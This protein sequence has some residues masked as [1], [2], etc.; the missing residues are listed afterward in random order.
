MLIQLYPDEKVYWA[1]AQSNILIFTHICITF[2]MQASCF[3]TQQDHLRVNKPLILSP[4]CWNWRSWIFTLFT[5]N[6]VAKQLSCYLAPKKVLWMRINW[7]REKS[8]NRFCFCVH[9]AVPGYKAA[10][11]LG[12]PA[13]SEGE[14]QLWVWRGR[15]RLW[16]IQMGCSH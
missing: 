4:Q 1:I 11:S 12:W 14:W 3:C 10:I 5:K 8:L 16:R 7:R 15:K 2:S 6:T 13:N 9:V